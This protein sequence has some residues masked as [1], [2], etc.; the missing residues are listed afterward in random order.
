M[1]NTQVVWN[2]FTTTNS[3]IYRKEN[4]FGHIMFILPFKLVL[5]R[6]HIDKIQFK[7]YFVDYYAL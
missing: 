2:P 1:S 5:K 4:I 6:M 7:C 3:H